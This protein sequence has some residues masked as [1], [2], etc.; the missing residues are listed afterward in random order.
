MAS[1]F[2]ALLV[3]AG[4]GLAQAASLLR[5]D[6]MAEEQALNTC[7]SMY[8]AVFSR[9]DATF[10]R[11]Q[12][13][14]M[15]QEAGKGWGDVTAQFVFCQP[16]DGEGP[17]VSAAL[18]AEQEKHGDILV[19]D[20][21]DGY[22]DGKLTQKVATSM[23]VFIKDHSDKY[24]YMKTDD[25]TFASLRRICD[26]LTWRKDNGKDNSHLYLGVFAEGKETMETRHPPCRDP[27][28][29]WYEPVEK[30]A[31]DTY[32]KS[33]KGGPG[34]IISKS[35]VEQIVSNGIA[36]AHILNNEDKAVGVWVDELIQSGTAVDL[37]NIPGT[38]G[39][40]EHKKWTVTSGR[41]G[42]YPHFLHHHLHGGTIACM[43]DIDKAMD[44]AL[45]IDDCFKK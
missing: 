26:L 41:Y 15:W 13:R 19:M 32:P 14:Q 45:T 40:A 7:G 42:T 18:E 37:L 28:S 9:R 27:E 29:E 4:P 22:L 10:R 11:K 8:V 39:Y 3:A 43:H 23:Q 44:A 6:S 35:V 38:D 17:E 24:F 31:P 25:D 1:L 30:F 20:C 33:A 12:I 2:I 16:L 21:E 34:Y 5:G 36:E